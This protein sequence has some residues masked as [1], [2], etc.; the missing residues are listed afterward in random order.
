MDEHSLSYCKIVTGVSHDSERI[1]LQQR[2]GPQVWTAR[3]QRSK[4]SMG[5]EGFFPVQVVNDL[6][7]RNA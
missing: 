5:M 7:L 3:T 6:I 4:Y 2:T 1:Y